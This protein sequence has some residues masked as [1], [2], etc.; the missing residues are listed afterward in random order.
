MI[1]RPKRDQLAQALRQL[2]SGR[3]DNLAFDDL[4]CPG[5][6]TTLRRTRASARVADFYRNVGTRQNERASILL[7]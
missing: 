1:D 5:N 6:I 3:I 4:D 7:R 2:L